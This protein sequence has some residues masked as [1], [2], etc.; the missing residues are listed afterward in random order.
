ML[1]RRPGP[2]TSVGDVFAARGDSHMKI[3][4]LYDIHGNLPALEAVLLELHR[5][6]LVL[7]GGDVVWGPWPRET[8]EALQALPNVAFIMGNTDRD[9]CDRA[10]G[11]WQLRRSGH[12]PG[13]DRRW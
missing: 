2:G 11:R 3:A 12:G 13:S 10:E 6:D 9:V 8:M 5:V 1:A 4:A 7:V